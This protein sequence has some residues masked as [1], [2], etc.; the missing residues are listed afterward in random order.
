MGVQVRV[1]V[2]DDHPG[3]LSVSV[4][5]RRPHTVTETCV[6]YTGDGLYDITYHVTRPGPYVIGVRWSQRPVA[7]SPFLCNISLGYGTN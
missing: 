7:G 6:T 1:G 4:V 5:G 3:S 2:A